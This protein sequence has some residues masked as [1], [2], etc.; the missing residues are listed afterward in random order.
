MSALIQSK[1]HRDLHIRNSLHESA[2]VKYLS[3]YTTPNQGEKKKDHEL[4]KQSNQVDSIA[5]TPL[6]K[7]PS[8]EQCRLFLPKKV[9][10]AL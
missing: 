8:E 7:L 1:S 2:L 9:I 5:S 4:V 3:D 6:M 10:G